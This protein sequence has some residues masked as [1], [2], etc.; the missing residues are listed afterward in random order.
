MTALTDQLLELHGM[1]PNDVELHQRPTPLSTDLYGWLQTFAR[2][3]FFAKFCDEEANEMM[4]EVVETCRPDC[5]WC[6]SNPGIGAKPDADAPGDDGWVVHYVR[7]RG[8]ASAT[9]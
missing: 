4:Q 3:T 1:L 9:M 5:Y 8:H 6:D 2:N 7:L